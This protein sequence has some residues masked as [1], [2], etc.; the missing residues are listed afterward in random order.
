[1]AVWRMCGQ[2]F[3]VHRTADG[4]VIET[5]PRII[6]GIKVEQSMHQVIEVTAHASR[7]HA[8]GFGLN[9]RHP[10]NTRLSLSWPDCQCQKAR[11]EH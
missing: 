2:P 7:A 9:W 6:G 10:E 3:V 8:G 5:L 11:L 1:M 4:K